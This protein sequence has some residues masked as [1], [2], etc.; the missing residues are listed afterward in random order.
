MASM[1]DL[2]RMLKRGGKTTR[3][4]PLKA[5]SWLANATRSVGY[6]SLDMLKQLM[7][8]TIELGQ[9]AAE[10]AGEIKEALTGMG[11]QSG[12]LK[13]AFDASVYMKLGKE[14]LKNALEDLKSGDFYN[15]RRYQEY[16]DKSM[17]VGDEDFDFGDDFDLGADEDEDFDVDL[18]S[19]DGGASVN[20]SR[21]HKGRN[22]ATRITLVNNIGPDSPLVQATEGCCEERWSHC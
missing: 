10:S 9:S 2:D 17:D 3:K 1:K 20:V 22:E 15:E 18:T 8:N 6:S 16:I 13:N 21:S 19:D 12:K 4:M 7:P 14:G 5:G 11:S